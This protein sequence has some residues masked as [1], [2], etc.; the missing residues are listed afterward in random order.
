MAGRWL[1]A[2]LEWAAGD[3]RHCDRLLLA[4]AALQA[5]GRWLAAGREAL[6]QGRDV[7]IDATPWCQP[8]RRP[9]VEVDATTLRLPSDLRPG[10]HYPARMFG[11]SVGG[12]RDMS[13]VRLVSLGMGQQLV[14]DPNHPLAE[15][16]ARLVLTPSEREPAPGVRLGELF[17]GA[18]MQQIPSDAEAC[19][20]PPGATDRQ[21]ETDDA[22]FYGQARLVQHLDARCRQ[23]LAAC[24]GRLLQ[25]GSRVLDLM[26]SHDSHLPPGA[27]ELAGL[28][29]NAEELAANP[30][31]GERVVH[32]L[33]ADPHLPWADGCFDAA[34]CTASIEY[35]TRP[36]EV[37]AALVRVLRSRGLVAIAFSDRW[38]PSKAIAVWDRLHEF[39]RIGLVLHLLHQAGFVDLQSE[40][41]RGARRPDD[42]KY[43]AQ[44]DRGD[45]LF[46]VYG[47]RPG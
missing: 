25:P 16:Q 18:G 29:M 26:A 22:R 45:P 30:R 21:D 35:L 9:L 41:L 10:R 44:R 33:N 43:A 37:L 8:A 6:Q 14:V 13:P 47:R 17:A 46:L 23:E 12:P 4:E 28:G 3:V 34:I 24:Y 1:E 15:R 36:A 19:Y 38:F 7:A 42:D 2:R 20:F 32:D 40:S 31:L 39:E 5:D 27:F 11:R